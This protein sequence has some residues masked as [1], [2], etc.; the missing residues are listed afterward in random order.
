M[1][2]KQRDFLKASLVEVMNDII[3]SANN[4]KSNYLELIE[5]EGT[6]SLSMANEGVRF[7]A[8][9]KK[10]AE[11]NLKYADDSKANVFPPLLQLKATIL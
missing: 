7:P 10:H 11:A 5:Q 1:A 2:W 8:I 9:F 3:S 6:L 4:F